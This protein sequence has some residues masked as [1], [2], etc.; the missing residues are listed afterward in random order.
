MVQDEYF[1]VVV[2]QL[3]VVGL[4]VE[5][6]WGVLRLGLFLLHLGLL[7][8]VVVIVL[9]FVLGLLLCCGVALLDV[10]NIL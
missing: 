9:G 7:L 10:E 1:T 8:V 6:D 3:E 4:W 5:E 2:L